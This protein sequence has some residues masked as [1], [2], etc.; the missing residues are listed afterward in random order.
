MTFFQFHHKIAEVLLYCTEEVKL[1]FNA[2]IALR[3]NILI[4]FRIDLYL[5]YK[6]NDK[7]IDD[8]M[9]RTWSG[10]KYKIYGLRQV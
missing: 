5:P 8:T 2:C 7:M 6:Y 4:E 1:C 10:E 9:S 3:Y